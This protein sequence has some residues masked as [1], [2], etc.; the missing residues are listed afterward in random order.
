MEAI[1]AA[2]YEPG[3]DIKIAL[4]PASSS[5]YGQDKTGQVKHPGKYVLRAEAKSVKTAQDMVDFYAGL[6]ERYPIFSIEDGLGENDWEGWSVLT[7]RLGSE[8]QLVGD[9]LFVTNV[10]RLQMGIDRKVANSILIKVNQI[11]TL[12]ETIEAVKLALKNS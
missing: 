5:F 7:K 8:I 4:D 10:K 3:V 12:T 1:E 6:C 9:D 2:G 11:G